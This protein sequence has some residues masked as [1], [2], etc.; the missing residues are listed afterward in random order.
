[1]SEI[2]MQEIF[3]KELT[4]MVIQT[5]LHR[6]YSNLCKIIMFKTLNFQMPKISFMNTILAVMAIFN[7]KNFWIWFYQ[8]QTKD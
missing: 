4:Q 8:Q 6:S 5:S 2:L 3:M 1:M 7:M